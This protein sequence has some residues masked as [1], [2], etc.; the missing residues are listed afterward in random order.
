MS[1]STA[2]SRTVRLHILNCDPL[3]ESLIERYGNYP[4][5]F[6]ALFARALQARSGDCELVIECSDAFATPLLEYQALQSADVLLITGSAASVYEDKAWIVNLKSIIRRWVQEGK[7]LIGICFGHQL[8]AQAL[9]GDVT[10]SGR[11]WGLG[12]RELPVLKHTRWMGAAPPASIALLYSHQ[13]QVNRLPEHAEVILGDDFCP[14]AGFVIDDQVMTL[15]GHPEFSSDYI[16]EII[17]RRKKVIGE[18]RAQ[19]A[20]ASTQHYTAEEAKLA[21]SWMIS[22]LCPD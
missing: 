22:F 10:K 16:S 17:H 6:R 11:G 7:K 4:A 13:D 8:V 19:Q 15:Q 9:G 12:R 21:P 5:M 18:E 20:L 2:L 14:I 1:R 3:S